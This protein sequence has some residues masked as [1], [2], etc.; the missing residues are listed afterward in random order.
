MAA[1]TSST[2]WPSATARLVSTGVLIRPRQAY[3]VVPLP[4]TG[5]GNLASAYFFDGDATGIYSVNAE[6][7]GTDAESVYSLSG[8]RM[9]GKALPKGIYIVNGKKKVIK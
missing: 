7:E 1:T 3:L 6:V 5:E 4:E 2:S 8:I 9:D